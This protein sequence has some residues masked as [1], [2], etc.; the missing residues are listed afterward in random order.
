MNINILSVTT[1]WSSNFTYKNLN[2]F[3][4]KNLKKKCCTK[5]LNSSLFINT[6]KLD[7][8]P[9]IGDYTYYET[10]THYHLCWL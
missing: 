2:N 7:R 5:K 10:L 4:Y 3:T 6:I 9:T 1:L 8:C